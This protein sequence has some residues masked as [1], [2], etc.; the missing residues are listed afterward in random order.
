MKTRGTQSI[1]GGKHGPR[2]NLGAQRQRCFQNCPHQTPSVTTAITRGTDHQHGARSA[3]STSLRM[4]YRSPVSAGAFCSDPQEFLQQHN[5]LSAVTATGSPKHKDTTG[6]QTTSQFQS[7]PPACLPRFCHKA[8]LTTTPSM[9]S[10]YIRLSFM[11]SGI[12]RQESSKQ[13]PSQP[14]DIPESIHQSFP[15]ECPTDV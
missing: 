11:T 14:L 12:K 15:R 3:L 13:E 10:T 2:N 5:V 9:T 4:T 8:P 1:K 6:V 7:W